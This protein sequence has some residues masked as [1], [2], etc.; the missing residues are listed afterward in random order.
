MSRKPSGLKNLNIAV[1]SAVKGRLDSL[2]AKLGGE[3]G[4]PSYNQLLTKL[5]DSWDSAHDERSLVGAYTTSS[6]GSYK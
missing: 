4:E 3:F 1:N 2:K 5:L 6:S